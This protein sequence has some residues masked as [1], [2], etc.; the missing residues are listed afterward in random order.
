MTPIVHNFKRPG[1]IFTNDC[2]LAAELVKGLPLLGILGMSHGHANFGQAMMPL[3]GQVSANVS[4]H[5]FI[6]TMIWMQNMTCLQ[7]EILPRICIRMALGRTLRRQ[8]M[9]SVRTWLGCGSLLSG[10]V[11]CLPV[12]KQQCKQHCVYLR[13]G[14]AF[15]KLK[16]NSL[17]MMACGAQYITCGCGYLGM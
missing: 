7:A 15:K 12:A 16:R 14:I 1:S 13:G 17:K 5:S 11:S 6:S 2:A 8:V 9:S 10:S 4:N 3:L